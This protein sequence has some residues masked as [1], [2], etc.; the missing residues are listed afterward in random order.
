M[1]LTLLAAA[2]FAL[3]YGLQRCQRPDV[4]DLELAA[5][6]AWNEQNLAVAEQ[7]AREA[8]GRTPEATRAREVLFRVGDVLQRPE[9]PLAILL[10]EYERHPSERSLIELGRLAMASQWFRLADEYFATGVRQYPKSAT[11]QRQWVA[12]SGLR[13]DAE[14]M[15]RRLSQWAEHGR[16]TSDMVVMSLGLWSIDTRGA[17]PSESWLRSALEADASDGDSRLGL[18]R[19]YLAMGRYAECIVL[20]ADHADDPQM[21]VLLARA[22]ATLKDKTAA[23]EYLPSQ[24]PTALKADYWFTRGLIAIED[25]D[26]AAAEMALAK[27]VQIRPLDQAFRSRYCAVLRRNHPALLE[28]EVSRFDTVVRIAHLS[29]L[30]GLATQRESLLELEQMCR[31]VGADEAAALLSKSV[32]Q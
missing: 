32:G 31:S 15:Q 24:E 26:W 17:T 11:L 16:P 8:F 23:V 29:K 10:N 14:E 9:I 20:L 28:R 19:T 27:A 25:S 5:T 6:V 13:L 7:R 1:K 18:A 21:A 30:P 2:C 12:L 22:H 4:E 3:G